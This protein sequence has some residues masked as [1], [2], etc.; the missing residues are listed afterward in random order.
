MI[1]FAAPTTTPADLIRRDIRVEV[2]V[3]RRDL[4]RQPS[5]LYIH[6]IVWALL[7]SGMQRWEWGYQDK[8]HFEGLE[9]RQSR[10]FDYFEV[11]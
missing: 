5:L 11:R 3:M 4:Y 6:P 7:C 9:V 2:Y 8:A 1:D 10:A